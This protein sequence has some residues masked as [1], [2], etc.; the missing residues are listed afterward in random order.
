MYPENPPCYPNARNTYANAYFIG[1]ETL[2]IIHYRSEHIL[3]CSISQVPSFSTAQVRTQFSSVLKTFINS[4]FYTGWRCAGFCFCP[5]I[6]GPQW[7]QQPKTTS[8]MGCT[9]GSVMNSSTV[10]YTSPREYNIVS[11][12]YVRCLT[13]YFLFNQVPVIWWWPNTTVETDWSLNI[14]RY[15]LVY[16]KVPTSVWQ[17]RWRRGTVRIVHTKSHT[18]KKNRI[19]RYFPLSCGLHLLQYIYWSVD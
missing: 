15:L 12:N 4:L 11:I 9:P 3:I 14:N 13:T 8:A 18:Q 16:I 5:L 2:I 7:N 1:L 17:R 6:C 10:Y 19:F